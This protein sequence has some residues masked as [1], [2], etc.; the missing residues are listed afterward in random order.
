[1]GDQTSDMGA[2]GMHVLAALAVNV[3]YGMATFDCVMA[4]LFAMAASCDRRVLVMTEATDD[5]ESLNIAS[6]DVVMMD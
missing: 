1:M 6:D 2:V 4:T 3:L 5:Q